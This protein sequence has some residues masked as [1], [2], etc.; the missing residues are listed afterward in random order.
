MAEYLDTRLLPEF[1]CSSDRAFRPGE[2]HVTRICQ[3]DVLVL[4]Q[5][6][7]LRFE[8]NR[9]PIAVG[10]GEYY[11]QK[12]GLYQQGV[13]PSDSPVYYYVHF[14]GVWQKEQGIQLSGVYPPAL[15]PL[16]RELEALN[17]TG[18][19]LLEKT[20]VFY[21]LLALLPCSAPPQRQQALAQQIADIL[22]QG[23]EEELPLGALAHRLH[24]S[25]NYL[26]RIFRQSYG[27]TP[28]QYLTQLRLEQ[29]KRLMA[30]SDLSLEQIAQACGFGDY[31]SFYKACR[32][33][34]GAAPR[35]LR[36]SGDPESQSP[37][38]LS[39]GNR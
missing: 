2:R 32:R 28:H 24:F 31:A 29:A 37:A 16:T 12:R 14:R 22:R 3:E 13:L 1:F 8:E 21:R 38:S 27:V 33:A 34:F 7:V 18:G 25:E 5:S 39:A 19:S 35:Q 4:V 6:G 23:L 15:W 11:I 10:P 26:I 17:Q 20:A 30:G 9:T 36:E